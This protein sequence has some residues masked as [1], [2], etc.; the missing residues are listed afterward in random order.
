[1]V[2]PY[3]LPDPDAS[4]SLPC[5]GGDR[6]E[7][8]IAV[9]VGKPIDQ[10]PAVV[11]VDVEEPTSLYPVLQE[12][13]TTVLEWKLHPDGVTKPFRSVGHGPQVILVSQQVPL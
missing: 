7:Q 8:V 12:N 5:D 3:E 4:T 9:Q 11:Q 13:L 10:V 6:A 2:V 1:M